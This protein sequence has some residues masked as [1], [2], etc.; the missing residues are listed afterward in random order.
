M[1]RTWV[2]KFIPCEGLGGNI[3][4]RWEARSHSGAIVARSSEA[5]ET[6]TECRK[7]AAEYGY[8][9]PEKRR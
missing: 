3:W 9:P 4:W 5:Y 6:L 7:S 2:W 1:G 8:L